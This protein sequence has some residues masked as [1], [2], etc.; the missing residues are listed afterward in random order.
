MVPKDGKPGLEVRNDSAFHISFSS[1]N[2]KSGSNNYPIPVEMLPPTQANHSRSR[3]FFLGSRRSNKNRVRKHQRRWRT[4]TALRRHIQLSIVKDQ[5]ALF[6]AYPTSSYR[7]NITSWWR[8]H[9]ANDLQ[10]TKIISERMEPRV[11][12]SD[13]PTNCIQGRSERNRQ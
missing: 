4:G 3:G 6:V 12:E 7:L 9:F 10:P 11:R 2:L 5:D 1:V 13:S 8:T